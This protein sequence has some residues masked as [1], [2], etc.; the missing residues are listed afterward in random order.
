MLFMMELSVSSNFNCFWRGSIFKIFSEERAWRKERKRGFTFARFLFT[1]TPRHK[2]LGRKKIPRTG[3]RTG[4]A[5]SLNGTFEDFFN[6]FFYGCCLLR[7]NVYLRRQVDTDSFC[8]LLK[9]KT[10]KARLW[11]T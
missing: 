8:C 2:R 4:L 11:Y 6:Y 5:F 3:Q 9:N 1:A 7:D 10:K